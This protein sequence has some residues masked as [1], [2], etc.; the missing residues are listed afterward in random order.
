MRELYTNSRYVHLY[1]ASWSIK[2]QRAALLPNTRRLFRAVLLHEENRSAPKKTKTTEPHSWPNQSV[3]FFLPYSSH[4]ATLTSLWVVDQD[5]PNEQRILTSSTSF[6]GFL[7]ISSAFT[8][9]SC[10]LSLSKNWKKRT[11][12]KRK[13]NQLN[14][15]VV[16]LNCKPSMSEGTGGAVWKN[17]IPCLTSWLP[18]L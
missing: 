17:W 10:G 5:K 8:I 2:L 9:H 14:T 16:R 11:E 3:R 18:S 12:R 6:L 13:E 4:F 7:D 15:K 1:S